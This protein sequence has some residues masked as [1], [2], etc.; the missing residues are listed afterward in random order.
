MEP[1]GRANARPMTGSAKSGTAFSA[2][3]FSDCAALHPEAKRGTRSSC[4]CGGRF[5]IDLG[6]ENAHRCETDLLAD[7]RGI[8]ESTIE[9]RVGEAWPMDRRRVLRALQALNRAAAQQGLSSAFA[10]SADGRKLPDAPGVIRVLRLQA[11]A[12]ST[13]ELFRCAQFEQQLRSDCTRSAVDEGRAPMAISR[14][15]LLADDVL[16]KATDG[17]SPF[18]QTKKDQLSLAQYRD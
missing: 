12:R 6:V 7:R 10:N 5:L 18:P 3:G 9:Q 15:D 17:A 8:G 13:R 2:V 11:K 16:I 1:T 4:C 14:S